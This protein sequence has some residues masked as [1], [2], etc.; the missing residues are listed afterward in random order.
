[1]QVRNWYRR[2]YL[3]HYD[4]QIQQTTRLPKIY[5]YYNITVCYDCKFKSFI[6]RLKPIYIAQRVTINT[7]VEYLFW[8]VICQDK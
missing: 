2:T 3:K 8:N 1:M 6:S 7:I 5:I 4:G